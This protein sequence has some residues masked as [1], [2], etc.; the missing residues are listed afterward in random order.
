[1]DCML[2]VRED[3]E[4]DGLSTTSGDTGVAGNENEDLLDLGVPSTLAGY[5]SCLGA[6]CGVH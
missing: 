4:D 1:M 6:N 2:G 3:W 5:C